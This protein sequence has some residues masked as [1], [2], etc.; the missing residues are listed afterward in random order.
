MSDNKKMHLLMHLSFFYLSIQSL[1]FSPYGGGK[2]EKLI[3]YELGLVVGLTDSL[4]NF[5]RK[6]GVLID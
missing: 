2:Y 4:Y 3:D 6:A 1:F 5:K